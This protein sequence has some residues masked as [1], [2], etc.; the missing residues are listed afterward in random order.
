MTWWWREREERGKSGP[1]PKVQKKIHFLLR[2]LWK[3]REEGPL[4]NM[5]QSSPSAA[6]SAKRRKLT[7]GNSNS[8]QQ[9]SRGAAKKS[10]A[11][12]AAP[13]AAAALEDEDE[14]DVGKIVVPRDNHTS[15]V[16]DQV[17]T[18]ANAWRRKYIGEFPYCARSTLFARFSTRRA[19][20]SS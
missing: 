16:N 5:L 2:R 15:C 10:A 18:F 14:P 4:W 17:H 11:T 13:V 6:K 7:G 3:N 12:V 8:K 9:P 20:W 19:A 1:Q